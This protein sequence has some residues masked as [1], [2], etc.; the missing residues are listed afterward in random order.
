MNQLLKRVFVAFA[1][2]NVEISTHFVLC[3]FNYYTLPFP[4]IPLR[5]SLSFPSIPPFL[6]QLRQFIPQWRQNGTQACT[7]QLRRVILLLTHLT[8]PYL[9]LF[10]LTLSYLALIHLR[11]QI[12]T[13]SFKDE[14]KKARECDSSSSFYT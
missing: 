9:T 7:I 13:S 10:Y 6:Q 3:K 4:S 11:L 12:H 2:E 1:S 8:S 5:S 14:R